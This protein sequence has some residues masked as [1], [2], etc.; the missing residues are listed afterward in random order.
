MAQ[1]QHSKMINEAVQKHDITI[2]NKWRQENPDVRPDLSGMDLRRADLKN[3]ALQGVILKDANLRGTDLSN[4]DL[5]RADLHKANLVL[6]HLGAANLAEADFSG[7]NLCDANLSEANLCAANFSNAVLVGALF[8]GADLN[9]ANLGENV[10]DLSP[11]QIK[12][13]KNWQY[14]YY[15]SGILESLGL[16]LDHNETLRREIEKQNAIA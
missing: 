1:E 10:K 7:A 5:S 11:F 16:P 9:K 12:T 6:T 8:Q 13:A 15:T 4:A 14:A 3:A 2:W